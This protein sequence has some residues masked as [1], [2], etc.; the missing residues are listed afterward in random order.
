MIGPLDMRWL[1][2]FCATDTYT[3]TYLGGITPGA[4]T[5]TFQ[6]G[7]WVR[8]GNQ[9]TVRGQVNWS[10][11]TGTG[12]AQFSLPFAPG[13]GNFT[14]A[15]YLNG[16]TF[17]NSAPEILLSAGNTYFTMGSPLTNAAPT[18]VQIEAAGSA[19]F[20]ITYFL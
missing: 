1:A 6:D 9:L 16:I 3:P 8:L 13:S 14:G 17:A 20:T 5:Y 2:T 4:T 18:I 12:N 11:A 15:L 10:A 7:A 19:V